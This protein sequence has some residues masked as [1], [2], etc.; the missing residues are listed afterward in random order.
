MT[1]APAVGESAAADEGAIRGIARGAAPSEPPPGRQGHARARRDLPGGDRAAHG[2]VTLDGV[3]PRVGAAGRRAGVRARRD[4]LG[5]RRA[6]RP[7][8]AAARLPPVR[9]R[10]RRDRLRALAPARRRERPLLDDPGRAGRPS[11]TRTTRR[12]RGWTR[13]SCSSGEA[14]ADA[15][16]ER[17]RVIAAGLGLPGPVDQDG[18]VVGSSVILPGWVGVPAAKEMRRRLD[19]PVLVDNDANLG[20][21]GEAV[22]GAGQGGERLRLRQG[23][24]GHR[25][26]ADPQRPPVPGLERDGGRARPRPG[27]PRGRGVPVREPRLP[28]DGGVRAGRARA[29]AAQPR[30]RSPSRTCCASRARATSGAGA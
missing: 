21:L 28:G 10:R 15:G 9:G 3:E 23:L 11:S 18:G 20:A 1:K 25:R 6:R 27:R 29:A 7:P 8:A 12:R 16:V 19:V 13:R 26:G 14:L 4:G 22:Y 24:L 5:A 17:R 30:R 2:P